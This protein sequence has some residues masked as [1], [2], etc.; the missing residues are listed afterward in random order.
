M[1][2]TDAPT[3]LV[4]TLGWVVA[5]LAVLLV[6]GTGG[7]ML[8]EG[9]SFVDA[10]FMT[11]TTVTTVGFGEIHPL[12]AGG[13]VFTL[14]IVVVG[15]GIALI[16]ISLTAALIAEGEIGG[17]ARRR[18]MDRRIDQL[19]NHIIVCAYGRVGRAAVRELQAAGVPHVVIDPKE[20][21]RERMDADD[22]LYLLE[23]CTS[24]AVLR[25]AGVE[26]ARS[27]ICAVDSD[28][29]NVYITLT[30]R[31]LNPRLFIVARSSEPGSAERLERA[32]ADRVVSPYASSGRHMVRMA[33]DPS[34]L[35]VFDDSRPS[36]SIEVE[37]R[38]VEA[39]SALVGT[40]VAAL[41]GTVL[42]VRTANGEIQ[43]SPDAARTLTAGDVVLLLPHERGAG[44]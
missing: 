17:R 12:D 29:T 4:R 38:L 10:M 35:D 41:P 9:W 24:E 36:T 19:N 28:A 32:G 25:R 8:L 18:R 2:R 20:D 11:V 22:V 34:V 43:P 27:L 15:V 16:G 26:R 13:R 30:A 31:S 6:V 1:H 3:R 14:A 44:R 5:A 21:L 7:Y 39:G 33:Q 37:E 42:V 23:D 40:R